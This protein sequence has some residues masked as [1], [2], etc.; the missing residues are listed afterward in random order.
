MKTLTLTQ[1]FNLINGIRKCFE[2][3]NHSTHG[4]VLV[5]VDGKQYAVTNVKPAY[6]GVMG[7]H[8]VL[9]TGTID[10]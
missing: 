7:Y 10:I 6:D 4:P 1:I 3:A 2:Q 5:L 8:I 9:E